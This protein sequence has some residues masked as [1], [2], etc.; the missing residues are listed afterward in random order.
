[1]AENKDGPAGRAVRESEIFPDG[2]A[3]NYSSSI[4][5]E[6]GQRHCATE[7]VIIKW[8]LLVDR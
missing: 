8:R 7:F 4:G 3:A 5:A 1:M 6:Q 2:P